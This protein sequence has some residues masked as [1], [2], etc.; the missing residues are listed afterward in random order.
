MDRGHERALSHTLVARQNPRIPQ[1]PWHS[2]HRPDSLPA[3][4]KM[5]TLLLVA[6]LHRLDRA[7]AASFFESSAV[8]R[9]L[10]VLN[11]NCP[12][13]DGIRPIAD[14]GS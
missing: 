8:R 11:R 5:L 6:L 4:R 9:Q 13:H 10:A 1:K 2:G 7:L 14:S 12:G 3:T